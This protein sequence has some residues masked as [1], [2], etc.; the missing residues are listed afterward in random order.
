V[1]LV[2]PPD[3]KRPPYTVWGKP[4]RKVGNLSLPLFFR[5]SIFVK[6][7]RSEARPEQRDIGFAG[8]PPDRPTAR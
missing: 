3:T 4:T 5:T 1:I 6:F 8:R 2:R 7:A